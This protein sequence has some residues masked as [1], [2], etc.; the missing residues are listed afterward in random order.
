[1]LELTISGAQPEPPAAALTP[2]E[3]PKPPE[4][5]TAPH[6]AEPDTGAPKRST[7]KTI[8]MVALGVGGAGLVLGAVTGGLAI[9]KHGA[10]K[11]AC[12]DGPCAASQQ[13]NVDAYHLMGTLSTVGFIVGGASAATGVILLLTAPRAQPV[14]QAKLT[15]VIGLGYLGAEGK[16]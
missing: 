4:D 15:P 1:V 3:T 2:A 10:L 11:E 14:N 13:G 9:G 5:L 12:G 7:R 6:D 16:F 8:G